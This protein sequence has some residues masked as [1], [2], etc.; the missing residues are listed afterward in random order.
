MDENKSH[1]HRDDV[2]NKKKLQWQVPCKEEAMNSSLGFPSGNLPWE[3]T[4]EDTRA[5]L[6]NRIYISCEKLRLNNQ[7]T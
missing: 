5:C 7:H 4:R 2:T 3:A 6:A 1:I